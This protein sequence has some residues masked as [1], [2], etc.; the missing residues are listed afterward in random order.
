MEY[1]ETDSNGIIRNW[2]VQKWLD[3]NYLLDNYELENR[4]SS[5]VVP[6]TG[7]YLIYA[8]VTS[9][10]QSYIFKVPACSLGKYLLSCAMQPQETTIASKSG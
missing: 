2:N 1:T 7:L 3:Q 8:Q 5:L 4:D 6:C 9:F 10:T